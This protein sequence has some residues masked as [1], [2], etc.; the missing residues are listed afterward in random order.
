MYNVF[1][2]VLDRRQNAVRDIKSR[3]LGLGALGAAMTGTG[4]AVFGIF[5][6]EDAAQNARKSLSSLYRECWLTRPAPPE[7]I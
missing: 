4:S 7:I 6:D 2:D 3:L 5:D 1:E